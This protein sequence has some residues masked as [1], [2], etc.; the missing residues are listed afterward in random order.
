MIV[1]LNGPFGGGKTAT[2]G[3]LAAARPEWRVFDP[4]MVGY[5]LRAA[6]PD[7]TV[8][9]DFQD[10]AAWRRLVV[11]SLQE[12][13]LQTGQHLIAPQSV[14]REDYFDEIVGR[15]S[16][17]GQPVVHVVLDA[18]EQILRRRIEAVTEA[19]DWRLARLPDYRES[20]HW[21]VTRA[22]LVL[23]TSTHEP[24]AIAELIVAVA[25]S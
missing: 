12:V 5:F 3:A 2:A 15:L 4:E 19:R 23:D 1:W 21:M 22:D 16:A 9:A 6:L 18:P 17:L 8:A 25:E 10:W 14:L 13:A 11:A 20:R 7:M 24:Q